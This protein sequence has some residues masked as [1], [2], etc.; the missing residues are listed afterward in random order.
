M[1]PRREHTEW[2]WMWE[3]ARYPYRLNNWLKPMLLKRKCLKKFCEVIRLAK[4]WVLQTF[5]GIIGYGDNLLPMLGL[6]TGLASVKN[7]GH[8]RF[9]LQNV[10]KTQNFANLT[11]S[12]FFK[13]ISV[14]LLASVKN[15]TYK[16]VYQPP[17][18][19][20]SWQVMLY[21]SRVCNLE[22][23][24]LVTVLLS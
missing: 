22:I 10:F 23:S 5:W 7:H 12:K 17:T 19:R 21:V 13:D 6:R 14:L 24:Y 9:C 4:F 15:L 2:L 3:A 8:W 18:S 20:G 1:L 11:T 16:D